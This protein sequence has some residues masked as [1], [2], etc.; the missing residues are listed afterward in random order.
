MDVWVYITLGAATAQTLRFMLQKVLSAGQLSAA[1]A[2]FARFVYSAPL[3]AVMVWIYSG[4]SGQGIPMPPTAFWPYAIMGGVSQIL[5]TI[6]VVALFRH[7]AFAVGIT[8]KKTEVILSVLIGIVI[9]GDTISWTGFGAICLGLVGVLLL[10]D[11]PDGSGPWLGR[12]FNRAA[13]LGILSG[14]FFGFSGVGY[15]GASLSLPFGDAFLRGT[16]TLMWVT[17]FQTLA[18]GA[19]LIW[20]E[21]G[22]V[23]RVLRAWRVASLVGIT[24]M[25]GSTCWFTAFTLQTAGYVNA[26]GQAELILSLLASWLVFREKITTREIWGVMILASSI[27]ILIAVA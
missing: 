18:L 4:S 1:G 22:E 5:A 27:V 23:M 16:T 26:V 17:A 21:R 7:R 3:V 12:L 19:W 14:I 20:R 11:P 10:S 2:T 25:I 8:F 13:G 15:R 24:S 6:C 9:L